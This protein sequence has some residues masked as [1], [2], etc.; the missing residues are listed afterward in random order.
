MGRMDMHPQEHASHPAHSGVI[1]DARLDIAYVLLG[2]FLLPLMPSL[3]PW[4]GQ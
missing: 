1:D 4:V 3:T 2:L